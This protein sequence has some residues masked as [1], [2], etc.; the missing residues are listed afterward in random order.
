[1]NELIESHMYLVSFVINKYFFA[2]DRETREE[3]TSVGYEA[4]VLAGHKYDPKIAKFSTFAVMKIRFAII[5]HLRKVY[6][7]QVTFSIDN[8]L[9]GDGTW[10]DLLE[11][12][13]APYED[14]VASRVDIERLLLCLN[15]EERKIISLF[16][17]LDGDRLKLTL[18]EIGEPIGL[19]KTAVW[20]R[21]QEAISK[22][23]AEVLAG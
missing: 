19:S 11:D 21:K 3:M 6:K 12:H 4:L 18:K 1:M 17:G 7:D 10:H 13:T 23:R 2:K 8:E 5:E 14:E 15:E 22:L 20:E 16:L 9:D